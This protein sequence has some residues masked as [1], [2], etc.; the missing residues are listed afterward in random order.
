MIKGGDVKILKTYLE[1]VHH[2]E[3]LVVLKE[4]SL[5]RKNFIN[6]ERRSSCVK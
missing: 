6:H 5:S 3:K 2:N 4:Y 1:I